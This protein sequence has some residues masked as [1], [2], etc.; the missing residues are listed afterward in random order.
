MFYILHMGTQILPEDENDRNEDTDMPKRLSCYSIFI[1]KVR[2]E[3]TAGQTLR[4]AV[5]SAI[6][7]CK[8]NDLLTDYFTRKEQ[9]EVFD[10]VN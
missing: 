4:Q 6:R 9:E 10:M 7:Y 2:K 1:D 3:L 5:T 8:E